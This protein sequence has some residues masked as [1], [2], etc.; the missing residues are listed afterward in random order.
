ME[1][2]AVLSKGA[3][4]GV[5]VVDFTWV[6]A[7]PQSTRIF[8]MFGAEVIRI[9]WPLNPDI[10]RLGSPRYSAAGVTPG[11]DTNG[12]FNNFNC[13]KL[14]VTL[15]VR[16]PSGLDLIKRL[17]G[18]SDVVIENFSS[19]V[20]ED[21]GLGYEQLRQANPA[22]IYVSM[23]G[24]GHSGPNRDYDT[25]GPAVQALSGLTFMSGLP[26]KPSAGWGHSYMDHTGGYYGAMATLAALH[27]RS[28]TGQG[29]YVD[30]AQVDAGCT[31]TGAA[32]LDS[33]VN[34]R[35]TD[36][37]GVPAGNRTHWPGTPLTDTYRGRHA[38]PHNAYRCAGG[39]RNDWCTIA[40]FTEEEW[41]ALAGAMGSPAWADEPAF[42]TLL[43]RLEHQE[44]LDRRIQEWT[45]DLNKYEVMD[46]LQAAGVPSA[47]VQS[48]VDRVEN[49]PQLQHR[50]AFATQAEHPVIGRRIYEGMPMRL[51]Q[52][53]WAIWRHGPLIGQDNDYVLRDVLGLTAEEVDGN[54]AEGVFW[55]RNMV[56]KETLA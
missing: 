51:E 40:C 15:N 24:F 17:I 47:P 32:I 46:R 30:L 5:R 27:Y 10:I 18:I 8:S 14:S 50:G 13:N 33:T 1:L 2:G 55:P 52:A 16:S 35:R 56:R 45:I 42:A 11:L 49:D 43:Q 26:G 19:R 31:L 7:G 36:R 28:R 22:I 53:P 21:W 4:A 12:D 3:L 29:Q 6:R 48:M 37:D 38:A 39:G 25:W 44:E 20:M 9:E 34:G 41:R 23:A 54:D